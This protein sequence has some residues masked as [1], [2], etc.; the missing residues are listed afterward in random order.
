MHGEYNHWKVCVFQEHVLVTKAAR[1]IETR[2]F[3][4]A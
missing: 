4:D 2:I 3:V 1:L